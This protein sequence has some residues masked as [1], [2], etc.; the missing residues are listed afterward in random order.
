MMFYS[1]N[2]YIYYNYYNYCLSQNKWEH[3]KKT[4]QY[5]LLTE[6]EDMLP[7]EHGLGKFI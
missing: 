4:D 5:M 2:Y 3:E 1:C 6:Q 7:I